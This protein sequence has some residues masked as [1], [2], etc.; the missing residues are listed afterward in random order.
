MTTT[1]I[2]PYPAL[3]KIFGKPTAAAIIVLQ[4]ELYVNATAIPN[5]ATTKGHLGS[6]M[7]A[8][9]Y[10]H[11]PGV[12]EGILLR[13]IREPLIRV[14]EIGLGV[15]GSTMTKHMQHTRMDKMHC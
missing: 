8:A 6:V 2:F 9:D 7:P 3:T 13:Y 4:G 10:L 11:K 15:P 14:Q 1:Q 5:P 12:N